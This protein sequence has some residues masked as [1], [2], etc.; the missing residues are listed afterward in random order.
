MAL[1]SYV[2]HFR[3]SRAKPTQGFGLLSQVRVIPHFD[4]FFKW[5][6]DSAA[7]H[8]LDLPGDSILVGID[9]D[10]AVVKRANVAWHVWGQGKLHLLK[11][12]NPGVFTHGEFVDLGGDIL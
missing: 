3:L 4:K 5:I 6:P 8:L 12:Q 11:G 7:K 9:E 2:P 10:T 1:S